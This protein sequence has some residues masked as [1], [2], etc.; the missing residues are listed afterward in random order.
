MVFA[1]RFG[2]HAADSQSWLLMRVR[3][4]LS[5]YAGLWDWYCQGSAGRE[6]LTR[7]WLWK[8]RRVRPRH[9]QDLDLRILAAGSPAAS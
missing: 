8:S 9:G 2:A 7:G 6:G 1:A 5:P 4:A 3:R